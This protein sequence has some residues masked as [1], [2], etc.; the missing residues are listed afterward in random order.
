MKREIEKRLEEYPGYFERARRFIKKMKLNNC[1]AR[2]VDVP[3]DECVGIRIDYENTF[4]AHKFWQFTDEFQVRAIT[5]S[6]KTLI[7]SIHFT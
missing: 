7:L 4:I 1:S 2:V 6:S 5:F 3:E